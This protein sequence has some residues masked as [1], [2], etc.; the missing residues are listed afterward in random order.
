MPYL[1]FLIAVAALGASIPASAQTDPDRARDAALRELR[2]DARPVSQDLER[3]KQKWPAAEREIEAGIAEQQKA[4]D[5]GR[6]AAQDLEL[7]LQKR[8]E[9]QESPAAY[10]LHGRFLGL[11]E[12]VDEAATRFESAL[13]IDPYFPWAHHGLG[14]AF[15]MRGKFADASRAYERALELNPGFVRSMEPLAVCLM[16]QNRLD[17]AERILRRLLELQKD[18][19]LAWI[20]L[21][22]LM[23]QRTRY[24][25]AVAALRKAVERRPN[26]PEALK[27]LALAMGRAGQPK[28]AITVYERLLRDDPND[29]QA[30]LGIAN[31]HFEIGENHVAADWYQKVVDN[32]TNSAPPKAELIPRIA[33]LR[34][35]PAVEKRDPR[36]K[37]PQEWAQILLNSTE[38]ERC[39]EAIR[40]LS[41][42]PEY[43]K[44]VYNAFLHALKNKDTEV[45]VLAIRE[46]GK[47]WEG[48]LHELTPILVLF[49]EDKERLV[50]AMAA[51]NLGG[52][53]DP[54]AV[55]SLVKALKERD[56]YVF[57]EVHD[58]LWRLTTSDMPAVL[59]RDLTPEVMTQTQAA[60]DA[61]YGDN[62]DRYK[63]FEQKPR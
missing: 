43:D 22:K 59:P 49:L 12:R 37:S 54:A 3:S 61:W 50:R 18:D 41:T 31:S 56:P 17:D 5:A 57:R 7:I 32:W 19:V 25:D 11:L 60:W 52:S 34:R 14:T 8:V 62:S 30:M 15:A 48:L 38:P 21:G 26:H 24:G 53:E 63:K 36:M 10:Y 40:V 6:Q 42:Y 55:P 33:E 35:L 29:V 20:A 23:L 47:R 2:G 51:R 58:A 28:D 46:L 44:D 9:M 27:F 4:L 16:Q 13:R 39:R 1:T 45:K